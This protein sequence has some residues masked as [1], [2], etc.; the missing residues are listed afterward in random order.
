MVLELEFHLNNLRIVELS[1][2]FRGETITDEYEIL[3]H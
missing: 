1:E 3:Q 2:Y